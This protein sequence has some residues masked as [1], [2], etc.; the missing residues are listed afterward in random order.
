LAA[1]PDTA[2]ERV[3]RFLRIT[4]LIL[5]VSVL[6]PAGLYLWASSRDLSRYQNQIA[7]QVRKATG[8]E[9][10]MRGGLHVN[11]TLSPS[12]VAEDVVLANAPGGSRPDMARIKRLVF[13]LDPV[14]LLL[15]EVRIARL[16]LFGADI[17]IEE[18]GE[19]RSNL[20]MEPPVEGSGPHPSEHRSLRVRTTPTLPWISQIDVEG[21]TLTLRASNQP[22]LVLVIDRFSGTAPNAN[23][24]LSGEFVGRINN[25]EPLS[26]ALVRAGTFDGWLKGLPGDLDMRGTLGGAPVSLS[27][28]VASRRTEVSAE[29]E[30]RSLA[31]LGRLLG[32][33]LPETAPFALKVRLTNPRSGTRLDVAALKIGDSVFQ[34]DIVLRPGRSGKPT[35]IVANLAGERLDLA[36]FR[37]RAPAPAPPSGSA[38]P[39]SAQAA[40]PAASTPSP[41]LPPSPAP[42]APSANPAPG[43][44]RVIPNDR[45]PVDFIRSWNG[46][47]ALR[48]NQVVGAAVEIQAASLNVAVND[49][50]LTVRPVAT[51]GSGQIGLEAQIDASGAAPVL[52][53]SATTSKLP[54]DALF[55]LL[56]ISSGVKGATV[57]L[58]MRLRGSGRSLRESLGLAVGNLDF[59]L[60]KAE[61]TRE[62]AH[63]FSA[64]WTRMLGLKDKSAVLNCA[65]GRIEFGGRPEGERGAA[66]IRKLVLDAPRFTAI[67]GGYIQMRNEEVG[68]LLWPEPRELALL[69]TAL[70]LRWTGTLAQASAETDT[71]AIMKV[72][73]GQRVASLTA[74][75][76][77]AGRAPGGLNPCASVLARLERLRPN[78]RAQLPRPPAVKPEYQPPRIR[79]R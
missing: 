25:S 36:D 29:L 4:A 48:V 26:L 16:Q 61:I 66:N 68:L 71:S 33:T 40:A 43:D 12:A 44:G 21:S 15:G 32:L 18:D 38:P 24:M 8:R 31:G 2:G 65:A 63:L 75:I 77:A 47:L 64:E 1:Q 54:L 27:G 67:G 34:G 3:R 13:H 41:P 30:G 76:T 45:Y 53:L 22:P 79:R 37:P 57:D 56:D 49:G 42:P 62:A 70:P 23:A 58:E 5:A 59:V 73:A 10:A 72:P 28:S 19:G 60:G 6:V 20:A 46:S 35:M 78:L 69:A 39:G 14:S 9:L 50:K 74:A 51:I 11:F 55:A 17:L 7:E 52:T